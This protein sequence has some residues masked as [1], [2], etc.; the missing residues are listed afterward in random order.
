MSAFRV[1]V[2]LSLLFTASASAQVPAEKVAEVP[3]DEPAGSAARPLGAA[4][5]EGVAQTPGTTSETGIPAARSATSGQPDEQGWTRTQ[6]PYDQLTWLRLGRLTGPLGTFGPSISRGHARIR[7]SLGSTF[8]ALDNADF[9]KRSDETIEDELRYSDDRAFYVETQ[10][11][12]GISYDVHPEVRI[13][14]GFRHRGLWGGRG[15]NASGTNSASQQYVGVFG[16]FDQ[17]DIAYTPKLPKPFELSVTLG[18]HNFFIGGVPNE[19]ILGDTLDG[20]SVRLAA[21]RF[22]ALRGLVDLFTA[23]TLSDQ[24]L[25]ELQ[26]DTS[27]PDRFFRGQINTVRTGAV[28]ENIDGITPGLQL[29]AYY[30][31]AHIGAS[32]AHGTG[33]DVS[34]NG[35]LGN[36]ADNDYTYVYG[37]R[38]EYDLKLVDRAAN[39]FT[40]IPQGEFARSGGVDRKEAVARDVETAGNAYGGLLTLH[41]VLGMK[42]YMLSGA[43]YHFDGASYASDG[44]MFK[45]GFVSMNAQNVGGLATAQILGWRP[46]ASVDASGIRYSP[47]DHTRYAGTQFIQGS[48]AFGYGRTRTWLSYYGYQDTSESFL[49]FKKLQ[50]VDPPFGYSR[51]E[52]AAEKRLGRSL[53]QELDA[54][55]EYFFNDHLRGTLRGGLLLPASFYHLDI[56]P[57]AGD[58]IGGQQMFWVVSAGAT[59]WL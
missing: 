54:G 12:T 27:Q 31:Y 37:G 15:L 36:F 5:A 57:V 9:R 23:S 24:S 48:A 3:A 42:S 17:L 29:R 30:L 33:A 20:L 10:L 34:Y 55:I 19:Y 46:S 50:Q 38:V 21:G 43:F 18:R 14:V 41:H 56:A 25:R 11:S 47:H 59:A 53:A 52:M 51:N 16:A 49:N 6:M 35:S 58:Q 7:L 39:R 28:Y 22:G 1:S 4:P 44:L 32:D 13:D 45:S 40:I 26:L 8:Y 2:L